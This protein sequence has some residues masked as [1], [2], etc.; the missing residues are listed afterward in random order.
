MN[1]ES[2]QTRRS[3][4]LNK[5]PELHNKSTQK[6]SE[7]II[8]RK[9]SLAETNSE[10]KNS[11]YLFSIFELKNEFKFG[12]QIDKG[13]FGV[14][15]KAKHKQNAKGTVAIKRILLDPNYINRELEILTQ[16]KH[17]NCVA[18]QG[19]FLEEDSETGVYLNIVMDFWPI[20]LRHL[21]LSNDFHAIKT[22]NHIKHYGRQ[23]IQALA[24]LH[25]KSICHRDVKPQN[26]LVD[27]KTSKLVLCDFGSAKKIGEKSKSVAYIGSRFYRAPE[28]ILGYEFY[29]AKIDMWAAGCVLAEMSLRCPIFEGKNSSK[30][31]K[32]IFDVLGTPKRKDLQELSWDF[33][34]K[35]DSVEGIGL[36]KLVV[37][38]SASFID[39]LKGLLEINPRKR[40]D[41]PTALAH[42]FLTEAPEIKGRS[43]SRI[44]LKEFNS[45]K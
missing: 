6:H 26:V 32:C 19:H 38:A 35:I 4:R 14:V 39:F 12:K 28:L 20:N 7:E 22:E 36:E 44:A 42:E 33:S 2:K 3:S 23:L 17:P 40:T 25:S 5:M 15:F 27:S 30:Q 29:D 11:N 31:L 9:D 45:S 10:I 18:Y 21:I 41:A 16:I 13:G 24:Y 8:I 37:D 34:Q 43:H 1:C